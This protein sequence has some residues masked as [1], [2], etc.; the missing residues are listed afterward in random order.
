MTLTLPAV[1]TALLRHV[2]GAVPQGLLAVNV[3]VEPLGTEAALI[4][5]RLGGWL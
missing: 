5:H 1:G 2:C 3:R 4:A